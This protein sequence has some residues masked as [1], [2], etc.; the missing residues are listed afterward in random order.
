MIYNIFRFFALLLLLAFVVMKDINVS[1]WIKNAQIQLYIAIL[2]VFIMVFIDNITGFI[3]GVALL[4]LYFKIYNK[5]LKQKKNPEPE[6]TIK[7]RCPL[8]AEMKETFVHDNDE[9]VSK[10]EKEGVIEL[11]Y[12]TEEHLLSAQNNIVDAQNYKNESMVLVDN[13][14]GIKGIDYSLLS[15]GSLTY[16]TIE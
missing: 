3:L 6:K 8:E 5:E 1:Q 16:S 14:T 2:I 12:V 13:E 10:P 4:V 7:V 15:L 11:E 9:T